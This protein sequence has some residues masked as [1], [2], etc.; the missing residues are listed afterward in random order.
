MA[1]AAF[2]IGFF[3]MTVKQGGFPEAYGIDSIAFW[4]V[5]RIA[6]E[7]GYSE[8]YDVENL[9]ASQINVLN[10]LDQQQSTQNSFLCAYSSSLSAFICGSLTA[11]SRL[12]PKLS[13]WIW[14]VINLL[15]LLAYLI[16]S[17]A[18]YRKRF[19]QRYQIPHR[20]S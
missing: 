8:I 1:V 9:K 2:Y 10:S 13:F 5:G 4:S 17:P 6:D 11:I 15:V 19:I 16:S 20:R 12:D 7:K 3:A 14:T 18:G